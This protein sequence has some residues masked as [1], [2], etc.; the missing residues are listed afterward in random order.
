MQLAGADWL[1]SDRRE[2]NLGGRPGSIVQVWLVFLAHEFVKTHPFKLHALYLQEHQHMSE[3]NAI[4]DPDCEILRW[5]ERG[6]KHS[7]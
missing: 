2:D 3:D 1:R 5:L 4:I 7:L 6:I